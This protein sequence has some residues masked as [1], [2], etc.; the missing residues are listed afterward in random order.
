[1]EAVMSGT[2]VVAAFL[3]G[4]A[5]GILIGLTLSRPAPGGATGGIQGRV[6]PDTRSRADILDL[7]DH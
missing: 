6:P 7:S 3:F 1:M 4:V 2:E 5:L